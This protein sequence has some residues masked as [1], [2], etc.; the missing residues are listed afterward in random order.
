MKAILLTATFLF[1]FSGL[2]TAQSKSPKMSVEGSVEG[3]NIVIDYSAPSV[4]EREIWGELV[5]YDKVW[6]TGANEATTVEFD[7]PVIID[8]SELPAGKY[9]LFTI[10]SMDKWTIIFNSNPNQWGA[11][12]YD[13]SLDVLKLESGIQPADHR[14][15][16]EISLKD[17]HLNIHWEKTLV[18][19]T[20]AT[21][22]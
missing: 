12:K 6:R 1:S 8:G 20:L 10:P 19:L 5:P 4:R 17:N 21:K 16:M 22:G 2:T 11:Y 18:S 9:A 15:Q 14:E 7:K 3:V 13:P